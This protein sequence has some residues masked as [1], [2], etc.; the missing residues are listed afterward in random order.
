M[1]R[2]ITTLTVG[3]IAVLGLAA[4]VRAQQPTV[5]QVYVTV[6]DDDGKPVTGLTP[7]DFVVKEGGREREVTAVEP[8]RER[9]RL[10]I[11]LEESL[12]PLGGVRMGLVQFIQRMQPYAEMSLV[13][14]GLRNTTVVDYTTDANALM[15]GVNNLSMFQHRQTPN[16]LPEGIYE[17]ARAFTKER[18]ERPVIVA[19]AIEMMQESSEQPQNV[20]NQ[21]AK[22]GAVLGVVAIEGASSAQGPVGVG[23][24]T[25]MSG[26]AQVLGDGTR[27][28]GGR[29]VEVTALTAVGR[30][31]QQ[32]ADDL[33]SQ[34]RVTY[35]L[36]AG[37]ETSNRL[38]VSLSRK[39][40]TLLAPSR[41]PE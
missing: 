5:R 4:S 30:A 7:A 10:A 38:S 23:S 37:V 32:V 11:L 41:I 13:L 35:S 6:A 14:V 22:S 27:Q 34:Y 39:D 40:L 16:N 20:L 33:T 18:P 9:M 36:P 26:R 17:A 24:L 28:S 12:T 2:V 19:V 25:E 21:I 3:S 1:R 15:A 31:M 8:A 29:R